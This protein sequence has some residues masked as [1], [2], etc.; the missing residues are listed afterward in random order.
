MQF[1][2]FSKTWTRMAFHTKDSPNHNTKEMSKSNSNK[3]HSKNNKDQ[4][5][6]RAARSW[7]WIPSSSMYSKLENKSSNNNIGKLIIQLRMLRIKHHLKNLWDNSNK[8]NNNSNN[9]ITTL[10]NQLPSKSQRKA[11]VA[12]MNLEP[13]RASTLSPKPT[14]ESI[15]IL[16][17]SLLI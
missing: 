10:K 4:S 15:I 12:N 5:Q 6:V 8:S 16:K 11:L 13:R 14:K 1:P 7:A 9:N 2:Q 17:K 3:E